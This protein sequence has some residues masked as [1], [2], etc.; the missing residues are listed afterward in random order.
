MASTPS[1][2]PMLHG[3]QLRLP[4]FEGPLDVLLRLI[5]REQLPINEISLLAVMDQFLHYIRDLESPS[6]DVIAEFA[7]VAGRLSALKSRALLPRPPKMAEDQEEPDLVRQMEEYRALKR[8]AELLEL[9][10]REVGGGFGRGEG[11]SSPEPAPVTLVAQPPAAISRAVLRWL[12]RLSPRPV[13]VIAA[14]VVT[15]REMV[16]RLFSMLDG[17]R[18][19]QFS[20]VANTCQNRQEVAVAFLAMLTLVR[21]QALVAQQPDLFGAITLQR[22]SAPTLSGQVRELD[23]DEVT[24]A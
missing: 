22:S 12:T 24:D 7:A 17:G 10:Q 16:S 6:P 20:T 21:R 5:E 13:E 8:A 23:L 4:A 18:Q 9:R 11:I 14:K 1:A 19:I 3:Y 2:A 15:L